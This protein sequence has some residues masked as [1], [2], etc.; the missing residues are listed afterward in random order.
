MDDYGD[1]SYRYSGKA[2]TQGQSCYPTCIFK[3]GKMDHW[4]TH[5]SRK[6]FPSEIFVC[7]M[8]SGQKPCSKGLDDP[9]QRKD[10]FATHLKESHGYES[11]ELIDEEVLRCTTK[12]TGL[13]HDKCGF[14]SKT[15]DTR[16]DSVA[17][18]DRHI[19]DGDAI[20]DWIY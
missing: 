7:R 19:E 1:S 9:F 12:V 18:I 4:Y 2:L 20:D 16:E 6:H 13:Y 5:Q 8:A 10:N 3:T 17:H 14:C 15:L 11:G